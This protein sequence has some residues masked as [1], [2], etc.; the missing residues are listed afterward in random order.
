MKRK[1][2]VTVLLMTC[3]AVSSLAFTGC[4]SKSQAKTTTK[5]ETE[6]QADEVKVTMYDS[7]G[8]TELSTAAVKKGE[9]FTEADPKKD[10]YTF[11]GWYVTPEL[12]RKFDASK[13]LEQDTSLY[14]GFAKYQEDTREFYI[15]GNGTSDVLKESNWG[16]VV[17]D[18]Q[19]LKKEDNK[20]ENV[21]TI[22]LDLK[23]GDQFQFAM[24]ASW[25]DQRGYGY[26]N[27]TE[28]D[29]T[30]YFKNSGS[31]GDAS[32]KKSNIEVAVDGNYTFTLVTHPLEDTYDTEDEHYSDDK[33]ENFNLNP[34]DSISFV[35]N[36]K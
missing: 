35:Y 8:K 23:A 36:G 16:A 7:D 13:P 4:G 15:V 26:L 19:K 31:L 33:K 6:A 20:E 11:V 21:Y 14:A 1:Q 29:G 3:M 22:T 30:E 32:V 34:Y 18:A 24:N 9:L 10:G 12:S 28:Q 25:E 17:G 5:Q 27:T 2:V